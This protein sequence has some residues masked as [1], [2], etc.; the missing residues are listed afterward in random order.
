MRNR[1]LFQSW[2]WSHKNWTVS[3]SC[4]AT[5]KVAGFG[6]PQLYKKWIYIYIISFRT[7]FTCNSTRSALTSI[8]GPIKLTRKM[9]L[10]GNSEYRWQRPNENFWQSGWYVRT[11]FF[12]R[13]RPK[14]F[15]FH[16]KNNFVWTGTV[17]WALKTPKFV[18]TWPNQKLPILFG[19]TCWKSI[20]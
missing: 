18:W 15:R 10:Q 12:K 11:K 6:C 4:S 9:G 2:R 13:F 8:D 17:H 16:Q 20:E 14:M 3:T 5:M 1:L 19:L 7:F